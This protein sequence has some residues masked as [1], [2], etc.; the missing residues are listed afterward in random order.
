MYVREL[1]H[2]SFSDQ[3]TGSK[4]LE[5]NQCKSWNLGESCIIELYELNEGKENCDEIEPEQRYNAQRKFVHF[6]EWL[7]RND[8]NTFRDTKDLKNVYNFF[9][10]FFFFFTYTH[11]HLARKQRLHF[12]QNYYGVFHYLAKCDKIYCNAIITIFVFI[13]IF[14][15]LKKGTAVWRSAIF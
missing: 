15:I 1:L 2:Y 14:K 6:L 4:V 3:Q 10:I 13:K 11:L 5:I 12:F 8:T 7:I 9:F